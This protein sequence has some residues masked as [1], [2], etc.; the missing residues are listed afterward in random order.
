MSSELSHLVFL[1]L[2]IGTKTYIERDFK[3]SLKLCLRFFSSTGILLIW[4]ELTFDHSDV[5]R[6]YL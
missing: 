3:K 5:L 6:V 4:M 1:I 2:V